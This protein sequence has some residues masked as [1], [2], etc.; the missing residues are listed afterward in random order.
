MLLVTKRLHFSA[1]HRLHNPKLSDAQNRE[2]Y[3]KC[4]NPHGHGHNYLLEVTVAGKEN[5]KTGMVIDLKE[6][7]EIIQKRVIDQV[8]HAHL[9]F[10]VPF[11]KGKIPTTEVLAKEFW[12]LLQKEIRSGKLYEIK[13]DE[14]HNNTVVYRGGGK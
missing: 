9:N 12:K 7:K 1:S 5:P 3:G 13:I 10:D 6:L 11:L 2:I 4:N 14:S 8:D